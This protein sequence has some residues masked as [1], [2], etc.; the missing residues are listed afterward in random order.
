MGGDCDTLTCIAGS[1]AEA[2]YGIPA[3]MMD[4]GLL[5]LT[6]EM[7]AVV[8]RFYQALKREGPGSVYKTIQVL[9][10]KIQNG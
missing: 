4:A 2:F 6:E 5:R 3:D 10:E 9:P 1:M 8:E 7:K